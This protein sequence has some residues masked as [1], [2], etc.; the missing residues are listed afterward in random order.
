MTT[1]SP[2]TDQSM[3]ADKRETPTRLAPAPGNGADANATGAGANHDAAS[4][5]NGDALAGVFEPRHYQRA[6]VGDVVPAEAWTRLA[7]VDLLIERVNQ[8]HAQAGDEIRQA[9]KDGTAA[10]F[11]EG[12]ARAQQQM[13]EQLAAL[14]EKRARVLG[15]AHGRIIELSCAIAARIAPGF[16]AQQVVP[17]LVREAVQAA[18]AE[19]FLLIRV[20]PSVRDSVGA[21]LGAVRQAHP[22]VGNIELVDDESLDP[23]S[24]VVVSEAGE[25]RAGVAQQIE[26]IRTALSQAHLADQGPAR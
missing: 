2:L 6:L 24:C 18:Q 20:H 19:Q 15:E 25:V 3:H 11:A 9:R 16:D 5:A 22:A 12:F 26:A 21:G 10:G 23:L 13:A 14:N 1:M 4:A 17:P 7:E 8:L